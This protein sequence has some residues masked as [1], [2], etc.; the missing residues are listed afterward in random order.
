MALTVVG[1]VP[2]FDGWRSHGVVGVAELLARTRLRMIRFVNVAP[3]RCGYLDCRH[4]N[5]RRGKNGFPLEWS[6]LI[7]DAPAPAIAPCQ[8]ALYLDEIVSEDS[9]AGQIK[10]LL[11]QL[12][13]TNLSF[14][15][16][17]I[18]SNRPAEPYRS[19]FGN[20]LQFGKDA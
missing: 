12:F 20:G 2:L 5:Q 17:I 8:R 13:L 10:S 19:R 1:P 9:L 11:R 15:A 4:D 18:F 16:G 6:P 14:L 3:G 7:T